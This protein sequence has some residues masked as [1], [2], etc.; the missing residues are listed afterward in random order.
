MDPHY[1]NLYVIITSQNSLLFRRYVENVC[2][3]IPCLVCRSYCPG[4]QASAR[5]SPTLWKEESIPDL[6]PRAVEAEQGWCDLGAL[7]ADMYLNM[8]TLLVKTA[9][10]ERFRDLHCTLSL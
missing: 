10:A 3:I 4:C 5:T 2:S 7:M 1:Q 8:C 9:S 6:R